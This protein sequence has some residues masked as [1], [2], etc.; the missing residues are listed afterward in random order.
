MPN[1]P[2]PNATNWLP[3]KRVWPY[4][5]DGQTCT[6]IICKAGFQLNDDNECEKSKTRKPE[7]PDARPEEQPVNRP[8]I[9]QSDSDFLHRCGATSC[10]MAL[11]G[12]MRK[13]AIMGVDSSVCTAKY[14]ACLQ[15]G[16]FV[17]RFCN[18]HGLAR[19]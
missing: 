18:L 15:T 12:C 1:W 19:N 2:R 6:R 8:P 13:T 5:P 3:R 16:S 11:R 7:M 14:N 4:R 10:S 17:G 9:S